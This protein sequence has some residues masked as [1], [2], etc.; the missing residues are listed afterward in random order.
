M[1]ASLAGTPTCDQGLQEVLVL[2]GVTGSAG[3]ANISVAWN[4]VDAMWW[5]RPE[6]PLSYTNLAREAG[7]FLAR[8]AASGVK[9]VVAP[10][11]IGDHWILL[12]VFIHGALGSGELGTV[13]PFV[14]DTIPDGAV[15]RG[16]KCVDHLRRALG[17]IGHL[18]WQSPVMLQGAP[19]QGWW[20]CGYIVCKRVELVLA[21]W[22][23]GGEGEGRSEMFRSCSLSGEGGKVTGLGWEAWWEPTWGGDSVTV[24]KFAGKMMQRIEPRGALALLE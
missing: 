20:E 21:A 8:P 22:T 14:L 24:I 6:L 3:P 4:G 17:S 9:L 16:T 18:M 1:I 15:A 12:L 2:T 19:Q 7:M 5:A 11:F 13:H 10:A 23:E